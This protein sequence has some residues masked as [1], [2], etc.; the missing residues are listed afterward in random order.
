LAKR[1]GDT[2]LSHY[3]AAGIPAERVLALLGK[4]CGIDCGPQ[5]TP[6]ELAE[7]FDIQRLPSQPIVF[8]PS[9]D[10]P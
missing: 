8:D 2:R 4:W 3:R 5:T 9:G 6:A 7:R 1:H 10:E